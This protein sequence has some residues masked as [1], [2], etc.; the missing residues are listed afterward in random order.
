MG[1]PI[2]LL[3]TA[4]FLLPAIAPAAE[5]G[6]SAVGERPSVL[7]ELNG[8]FSQL[9]DRVSPA[10]VQILG[11]TY[12]SDSKRASAVYALGFLGT[13][14]AVAVTGIA[15]PGGGTPDKPVGLVYLHVAAPAGSR[16]ADF[17]LPGDRDTIRRRATVTAIH[18]VRRFLQQTRDESV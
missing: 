10:V 13:E 17:V 16:S 14:V 1:N 8:A 11:L 5:P 15:G 6:R 7:R 3:A 12:E 2:P 4:A 18:L 9:A